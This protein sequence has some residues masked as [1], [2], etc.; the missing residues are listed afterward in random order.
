MALLRVVR[1]GLGENAVAAGSSARFEE[2]P[3]MRGHSQVRIL[4]LMDRVQRKPRW[5]VSGGKVEVSRRRKCG[6]RDRAQ[7][8]FSCGRSLNFV[9]FTVLYF[10]LTTATTKFPF[11]L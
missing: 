8:F 4:G 2:V 11:H 9:T 7:Y 5:Q 6:G 1:H 3:S 10:V